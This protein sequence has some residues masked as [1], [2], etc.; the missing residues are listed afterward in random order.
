M[1]NKTLE[2][3]GKSQIDRNVAL[4]ELLKALGALARRALAI[5]NDELGRRQK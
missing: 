2:E 3:L 4:T 1:T 5:V